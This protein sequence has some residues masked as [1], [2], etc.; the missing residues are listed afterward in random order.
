MNI[1]VENT[2]KSDE[3][4]FND[5]EQRFNEILDDLHSDFQKGNETALLEALM[6]CQKD[7]AF[8]LRNNDPDYD[9]YWARIP[10]WVLAAASEAVNYRI[11]ELKIKPRGK[12]SKWAESAKQD[13]ID[14]ARYCEV[15]HL[16]KRRDQAIEFHKEYGNKYGTHLSDE[17]ERVKNI[18][19]DNVFEVA[20]EKLNQKYEFSLKSG[21]TLEGYNCSPKSVERSYFKVKNTIDK[22]PHRYKQYEHIIL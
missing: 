12:N 5:Y 4:S 3:H 1:K 17:Y 22:E 2:T 9:K 14:Y 7:G 16:F 11:N 8:H 18:K 13:H 6:Q 20:A 21:Y 19:W 15:I 10:F